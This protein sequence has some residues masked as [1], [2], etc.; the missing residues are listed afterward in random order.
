MMKTWT[1]GKVMKR[2]KELSAHFRLL[3][4]TVFLG[5]LIFPTHLMAV[6]FLATENPEHNTT[7]PANAAEARAW[8][9]QG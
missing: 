7:P 5:I 4:G 2:S 3:S 8:G 1:L 6:F 9:L